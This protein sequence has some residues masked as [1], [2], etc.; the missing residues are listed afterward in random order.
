MTHEIDQKRRDDQLPAH[1]PG[2][3]VTRRSLMNKIVALSA[4]TAIPMTSPSDAG[5]AP[6]PRD[7]E[8]LALTE[9]LLEAEKHCHKLG[10]AMSEIEN[11]AR[12]RRDIRDAF[13]VLSPRETDEAL[14]LPDP[15]LLGASNKHWNN[16]AAVNEIR[17][18]KWKSFEFETR[19]NEE[20]TRTVFVTPSPEARA[21]G[22]EIIA[23]YD[24]F[25]RSAKPC[26]GRDFRK[27]ES[28]YNR[29]AKAKD[30]L[31][32]RVY[33]TPAATIEGMQ[34]KIRCA[35]ASQGV[36][37]VD[38]LDLSY[39]S[40]A[41]ESIFLDVGRLTDGRCLALTTGGS[42]A[43]ADR[44]TDD[45][46]FAAIAAHKEAAEAFNTRS[47]I[48]CRLRNDDRLKP[49]AEKAAGKACTALL[50]TARQLLETEPTSM[51]GAVALL[52]LAGAPTNDDWKF[53]EH[54]EHDDDEWPS[55][56]KFKAALVRHVAGALS[57]GRV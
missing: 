42:P 23:A 41:T 53:P 43:S 24:D 31:E 18:E 28:A 49:A 15:R 2:V 16:A 11:R 13:G 3:C 14:G 55:V 10:R 50:Q 17:Q 39:A 33:A 48:E 9:K 6:A 19:G 20:I 25:V 54:P 5:A 46:I 47:D 32:E 7:S 57:K 29:A 12:P 8:L 52:N 21:R 1:V 51:A 26:L 36:S 4:L 35:L 56:A 40:D 38:D 22:D 45:P 27:A 37:K 30:R 34:A 44:S